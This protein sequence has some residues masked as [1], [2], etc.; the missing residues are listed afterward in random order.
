MKNLT[1][2]TALT[3]T[4]ALALTACGSSAAAIA[5]AAESEI[6][7]E[8]QRRVLPKDGDRKFFALLQK[9]GGVIVLVKAYRDTNGIRRQLHHGVGDLAVQFSLPGGADDVKAVAE[10]K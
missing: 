10:G 9:L 6:P 7:Y 1:K 4:A 8:R 3:L 2:L 5:P